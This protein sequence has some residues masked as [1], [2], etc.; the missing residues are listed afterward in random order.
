VDI[1]VIRS[2]LDATITIFR[3]IIWEEGFGRSTKYLGQFYLR[4]CT[5]MGDDIY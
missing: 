4:G 5:N 1:I 3:G 2:I